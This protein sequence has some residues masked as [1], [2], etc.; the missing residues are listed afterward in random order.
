MSAAPENLALALRAHGLRQAARPALVVGARE[1]GY[2][3]LSALA[4]RL[5]GELLRTRRSG[6]VG[7]LASRSLTACAGILGT[8]WAGGTYVPLHLRLPE[9]RLRALLERLSL[10]ALV[11][12]ARGA[13]LLTPGVCALRSATLLLA[14]DARLPETPRGVRVRRLAELDG[15]GPERPLALEP[16]HVAYVEFTSGTTGAP[17]GVMVPT[18]AVNHYLAVAQAWFDLCPEDRAA[19][20]CDIT[21]D[22]SV[23]NMFLAWLGGAALHV[24]SPLEMVAP[25]RFVRARR[26]TTWLSV[27]SIV[28]LMRQTRAL[29]PGI[30]PSLRLSCFCGEPLPLAAA[31]AWAEAAPASAIEN[32]Y[33]PTEATV[34]CLRQP[35]GEPPVVTEEREIVAIGRPFPGTEA[36][37]LDTELDEEL[38]PVPAGTAGELALAGAQLALG[39]LDQPELTAARFPVLDGKR[40][41]RTGDLGRVDAQGVFHH[42]GRLD[43]QVKVLGNRVELEEV[44]AHLRAAAGTDLAAAVA[45]PS[46][47]GSA[48]GIVAFVAGARAE[49][50]AMRA[51]LQRAL[52]GYMVPGR[53]L[54]LDELPLNANGKV[55]RNALLAR[56][57][58]GRA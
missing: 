45:W 31:R 32:L 58:E 18:R 24:M 36:A 16:E 35:F 44:E 13:A 48:S 6:R 28:G 27:P 17:K 53:V 38:R 42:L 30:F 15:S 34:A 21:F 49:P 12:D 26:I 8:A 39:Y 20:T 41:Y 29:A 23:H 11:V 47:H 7:I 9:E 22:L 5:A 4:S 3:E 46:T 40:W 52:P 33:G 37:I 54:A 10:D 14:D 57:E 25:A 43:N 56:L 2:G 55:D 50:E 1:L 51:A 19:E